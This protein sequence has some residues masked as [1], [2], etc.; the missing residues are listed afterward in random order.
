MMRIRSALAA[1]LLCP[2]AVTGHAETTEFCLD[3]EFDLGA[4]YQ[5]HAA[6]AG[7]FYPARW[8]VT[9]DDSSDRVLLSISGNSN[10]D[11]AG[12]WTVEAEAGVNGQQLEDALQRRGFTLGHSP[13]SISCSSV[14][15][16]V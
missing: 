7:E 16:W 13:S 12:G 10:P 3:G 9:T 15:G 4:R 14:G 11:M 2:L 6:E 1:V 8:C 5:G